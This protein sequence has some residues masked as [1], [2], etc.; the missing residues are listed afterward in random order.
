MKLSELHNKTVLIF[1]KSRAFNEDEFK[2]QM[3]FHKISIAKEF[4]DDIAVL[5]DGRMMTPYEQ[6]LSDKLYEEK[7]AN[8]ISIDTLEKELVSA[9]DSNTLLMSLTLSKDKSRLKGFIQNSMI[10][11][12]LFFKLLHMYSWGGEDF[13]E[14]DDNRDV[15]AAFIRRFYKNIERNHNVE[16]ATTG[17]IHL[18]SQSKDAALLREIARL[19]PLIFHPKIKIAITMSPYCDETMQEELFKSG[20]EN[21][22]EALSMNKNLNPTL[23]KK[24]LDDKKFVDNIASSIELDDELFNLFDNYKSSLASNE[25]LSLEMQEKL[26]LLKDKNIDLTLAKNNN[27]DKK[28]IEKLLDYSDD[29]IEMFIYENSSTP[30]EILELAYKNPHYHLA[31]SKNEN[32]PIDILYQLQLDRRYER[33]VKSNAGFA[34]HIQSENIGWIV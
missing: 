26:L 9:I 24:F 21:I 16:Y 13:F 2:A 5:I 15:S 20:D 1:G 34:K 28:I 17:F 4:S 18:V 29:T 14:N 7:K 3:K 12:E 23:V 11:D 22:L 25:T 8:F 33:H 27:L 30:S 19:K 10:D 31:L 32:T 6:I